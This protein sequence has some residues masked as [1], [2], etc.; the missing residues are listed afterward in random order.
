MTV[1][2]KL[3][4]ERDVSMQCLGGPAQVRTWTRL[5]TNYKC[6]ALRVQDYAQLLVFDACANVNPSDVQV[7]TIAFYLLELLDAP[8]SNFVYC[9]PDTVRWRV[10][11]RELNS[12]T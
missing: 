10:S 3:D 12:Q 5:H 2:P 1:T 4:R 8:E 7:P 11:G 9:V 6:S